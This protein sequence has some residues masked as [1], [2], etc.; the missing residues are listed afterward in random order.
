M[1]PPTVDRE[2]PPTLPVDHATPKPGGDGTGGHGIQQTQPRTLRN[3][4]LLLFATLAV[5][6]LYLACVNGTW[7]PDSVQRVL[8]HEGF[9]TAMVA[10]IY[11]VT[12]L[13][14]RVLLIA[15]PYRKSLEA[16]I[17]A[18]QGRLEV[19]RA[20][21]DHSDIV[22]RLLDAARRKLENTDSVLWS[23]G[24]QKGA[25]ALI[26]QAESLLLGPLN[27]AEANLR[28]T[29]ILPEIGGYCAQSG[30]VMESRRH[31]EESLTEAHR[32][33]DRNA[34]LAALHGNGDGVATNPAAGSDNTERAG[35]FVADDV[36]T[37]HSNALQL[38]HRLQ[39]DEF[40]RILKWH[41]KV[42]WLTVVGLAVA[43]L[44]AT[45]LGSAVLM[46]M[47]AAGAYVARLGRIIKRA[48]SQPEDASSYW[49]NLLLGPL[50]GALAAYGGI[51]MLELL[52][53]LNVVGEALAGVQ[54]D[55]GGDLGLTLG[56][57]FLLGI[58]EGLI[59]RIAETGDKAILGK[60][61]PSDVSPGTSVTGVA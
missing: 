23:W 3:V 21:L 11:L 13:I 9:M 42:L 17:E 22:D 28:L 36:R 31:L 2:P 54:F 26:S 52:R 61:D 40:A 12:L 24:D 60:A 47:G 19:Q 59:N 1:S 43:V 51:L 4:G 35:R 7:C 14:A 44:L 25:F 8:E 30:F 50:L 6:T 33:V 56:V 45:F 15:R 34:A 5:L 48:D 41:R 16:K 27:A 37:L 29:L 39:L 18:V 32:A 10:A 57:A 38:L 58:S 20:K 49:T 53:E 46:L 55:L